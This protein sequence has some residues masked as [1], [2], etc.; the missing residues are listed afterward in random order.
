MYNASLCHYTWGVLYHEAPP[1]KGGKQIYR[2]EKRDFN[3]IKHVI[4]VRGGLAGVGG[5]GR[6]GGQA[7]ILVPEKRDTAPA[8]PSHFVSL[9]SQPQRLPMP[10]PYRDGLFL[11]FDAPLNLK[12]HELNVLYLTQVCMHLIPWCGSV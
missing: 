10:P 9:F 3:D 11:E 5:G 4:K 7:D 8:Y 12:R 6:G 2:W 1:S